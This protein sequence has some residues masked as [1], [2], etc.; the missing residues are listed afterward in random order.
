MMRTSRWMGTAAL[1]LALGAGLVAQTPV[2]DIKM[3]LWEVTT[4]TTI[5]GLTSTLDTSKM[6]PAQAAQMEAA[7][8]SATAPRTETSQT[9]MTK[10]KFEKDGFLME[11]TPGVTC[12]TTP[13]T[14]TKTAYAAKVECTGARA[15]SGEVQVAT[16]SSSAFKAAMK[17]ASAEGGRTINVDIAMTGKWI[18]AACGNVK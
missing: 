8:K 13:S 12:K 18:G 5:G 7:L 4:T 2:L 6:P 11:P 17:M 9:C 3:G 15:M 10:E 16:D 14:N 1:S